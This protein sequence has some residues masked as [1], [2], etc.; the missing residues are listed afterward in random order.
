[1]QPARSPPGQDDG[2]GV[3]VGEG[4]GEGKG[5]GEGE[6]EGEAPLTEK[7]EKTAVVVARLQ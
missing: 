4:E 1:M 5:E 2:V 6:G 7:S 3:G